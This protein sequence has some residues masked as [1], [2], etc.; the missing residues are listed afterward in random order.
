MMTYRNESLG[1]DS[2]DV[3]TWLYDEASGAMTNKVYADGK[4]PKYNYTTDGKLARR[5]WA[6]GIVADYLYDNWG[7][8]TNTVYSDNTPTV[9]LVYD[10]LGRQTEAHDAAGVTT[11]LYDSFGSPT[12]ETVIGV[13]GTNTIIRY[14]DEFGRTAGYSLNGI[15]QTI[16]G[17]EPDKGRIS[18]IEI[19]GNHPITNHYNSFSWTYLPGSDLKSSLSYPNGLT[20]SW[21]YDAAGQLLKVCNATLTNVISQYDYTYD[22]A[23]RRVQISR[24]GSAMSETRTDEYGYNIRGEL[25][26]AAKNTED[27]K[28]IEYQYQYD[29]IGNRMTSLDLGTNRTYTAN[30]LNQYTSISNSAISASP[31]EEFHPQFDDDG[32]QTLI[33]TATGIWQVTYNGENRPVLWECVSS[34]SPT[35]NSATPQLISMSYDRMGRRVTKNDLRFVYEGYLQIADNDGNVYFWDPTESVAT[36]SLAWNIG[37]DFAYYTHD[38]IK[39]IVDIFFVNRGVTDHYEYTPF[40][41]IT[42]QYGAFKRC[43]SWRFSCEYYDEDLRLTYFVYRHYHQYMGRWLVRDPISDISLNVVSRNYFIFNSLYDVNDYGFINNRFGRNDS[44]GLYVTPLSSDEISE[45]KKR[46]KR[47]LDVAIRQ[48]KTLPTCKCRFDSST[49]CKGDVISRLHNTKIEIDNSSE[50]CITEGWFGYTWDSNGEW[51][52]F[53]C[54]RTCRWGYLC[55]AETILHEFFHE[56]KPGIDDA[57]G[58]GETYDVEKDCGLG[59]HCN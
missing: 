3:T 43:N 25:I 16:I 31:R 53:I 1:P 57:S 45:C 19:A 4:G 59:S 54:P 51:K 48:I 5:I 7:N 34:N 50:G 56:C 18:T 33:Q 27:A 35:S 49:Y 37:A 23:G 40:G 26:S 15:R 46:I 14:W 21:Q 2:G 8:L 38:G 10:V 30:N 12:N 6:R 29:D 55:L 13:A 9:S 41:Y 17:Y 58:D 42:I 47:A 52:M 22:I 28:I 11:F 24:S 20:A 39:N 44:L 32:N 36:R